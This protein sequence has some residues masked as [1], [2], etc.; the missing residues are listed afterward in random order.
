MIAKALILSTFAL[1]GAAEI[2][3]QQDPDVLGAIV[4]YL[5]DS[6]RD[7]AD[8][9]ELWFR[10]GIFEVSRHDVDYSFGVPVREFSQA[11]K[12]VLESAGN[13]VDLPIRFCRE[14]CHEAPYSA[15]VVTFGEA[16]IESDDRSIVAIQVDAG[17]EKS[18]WYTSYDVVL[19]RSPGGEWTVVEAL[20]GTHGDAMSC[21]ELYGHSCEEEFGPKEQP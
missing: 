5:K 10:D 3:A 9:R 16:R 15:L 12:E 21:V 13:E 17:D 2:R 20:P 8:M 6:P 1:A 7:L 19:S 14:D 18:S 4:V 11:E